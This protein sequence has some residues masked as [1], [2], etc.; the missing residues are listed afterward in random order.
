MQKIKLLLQGG[1]DYQR[2][3]G[4]SNLLQLM[5]NWERRSSDKFGK[6]AE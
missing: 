3:K 5:T 6:E 4:L 1:T 2:L